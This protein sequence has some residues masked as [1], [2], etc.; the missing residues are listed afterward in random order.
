LCLID[1][2]NSKT[3]VHNHGK[4]LLKTG[5]LETRGRNQY[6]TTEQGRLALEKALGEA[7]QGLAKV[8]PPLSLVPSPYHQAAI[9]LTIAAVIARKYG[10]R[11]DKHPGVLVMGPT[12]TWKTGA[13]TFLCHAFGLDS[14][15]HI[16]NLGAEAGRSMFVRRKSTGEVSY[17]RELMGSLLAVLDEFQ[18]VD[19]ETM[20][21]LRVWLDGRRSFPYENTT[22]DA[23]A[24]PFLTMNPFEGRTLEERTGL[25]TALIRRLIILDLTNITIAD[26]AVKG[27]KILGAAK[28]HTPLILTPPK[29]DCERYK[30][31][32]DDLLSSTLLESARKLVDLDTVVMLGTAMTSYL[33]PEEAARLVLHDLHMVWQTLGWTRSEWTMHV[34]SFPDPIPRETGTEAP[35]PNRE[36]RM[37]PENIWQKAF[38]LLDKGANPSRL[39]SDLHITSEDALHIARRHREFNALKTEEDNEREEKAAARLERQIRTDEV[40]RREA[41][42]SQSIQLNKSMEV[43]AS[44][45][46]CVGRVKRGSCEHLENGFCTSWFWEAKPDHMFLTGQTEAVDDVWMAQPTDTLC[47]LCH[48]YG[49]ESESENET[50]P[51]IAKVPINWCSQT[52]MAQ[53]TG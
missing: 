9:E 7:P 2:T 28:A 14:S 47:A 11:T 34:K 50:T 43:S 46:A 48:L 23:L 3:K 16:V 4:R 52:R 35:A 13:G 40:R 45:V 1:K 12:I 26:L 21:F 42:L 24:V 17:R 10:L 30:T 38:R 18:N 20:R 37:I 36:A 39:V 8:Y 6:H 44:A 41:E 32:I 15:T 29:G 53:N 31:C 25:Q 51:R 33:E 22:L 49:D 19:A 5:L 27:D